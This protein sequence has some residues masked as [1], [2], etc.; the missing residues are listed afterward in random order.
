M[1]SA[2]YN[3]PRYP[4]TYPA[5]GAVVYRPSAYVVAPVV[6]T[7]GRRLLRDLDGRC[8]ERSLDADGNELRTELPSSAC[9]W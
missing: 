4:V 6:A 7:P 9:N 1:T 8:Y 5:N 2:Y 3:A